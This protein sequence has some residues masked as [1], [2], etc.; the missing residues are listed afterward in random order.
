MKKNKSAD[1]YE[2]IFVELENIVEK[3]DSGDISLE[4]SLELFEEGMGLI[5]DGKKKLDQAESKVKTLIKDSDSH[6]S[7]K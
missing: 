1:S 3:M 6:I 5:K 4:K 2:Q 7:K